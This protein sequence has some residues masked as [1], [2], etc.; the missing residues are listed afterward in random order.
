[1][2]NKVYAGFSIPEVSQ[3]TVDERKNTPALLLAGIS[4]GRDEIVFINTYVEVVNQFS[5]RAAR[6]EDELYL[7]QKMIAPV[8]F[9]DVVRERNGCPTNLTGQ[10]KLLEIGLL[11]GHR[12]HGFAKLASRLVNVQVFKS[13]KFLG[14]RFHNCF[15]W[16]KPLKM[17]NR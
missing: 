3:I 11:S 14:R 13:A 16:L 8:A 17:L 10:S 6:M 4:I 2:Q 1:M 15:V 7:I 5:E 12:I 9:S